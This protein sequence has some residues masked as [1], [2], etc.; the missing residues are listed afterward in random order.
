MEKIGLRISSL[1]CQDF[2][3]RFQP[4]C[5]PGQTAR[6]A[7]GRAEWDILLPENLARRAKFSGKRQKSTTL[8]QAKYTV[9]GSKQPVCMLTTKVL[10][11]VK[12]FVVSMHSGKTIFFPKNL[13]YVQ[14]FGKKMKKYHAA[15]GEAGFWVYHQAETGCAA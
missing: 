3:G 8:P 7:S 10:S 4:R 5:L 2:R 15:A 6:F 13:H 14:I 9:I 11:S 12:T 1:I